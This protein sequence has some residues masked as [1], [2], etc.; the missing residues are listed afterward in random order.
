MR[1][2]L[3]AST[4]IGNCFSLGCVLENMKP[5]HVIVLFLALSCVSL[6]T[7]ERPHLPCEYSGKV[8][9]K[10]PNTSFAMRSEAMKQRATKRV[11]FSGPAE[12]ADIRGT[13]GVDVLVGSDGS[14][15]CVKGFYGH[16]MVLKDV[17]EAVRLWKFKPLKEYDLPVAYVGKLY[18]DLCNIG[19]G[20]EGPSMT[21]LK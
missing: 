6:G 18:F 13:V 20:K 3:L 11:D 21:L 19:C 5:H 17:E 15:V 10:Y 1:Y 4:M 9:R 12:Q 2:R 14:V 8:S 16:P 7:K